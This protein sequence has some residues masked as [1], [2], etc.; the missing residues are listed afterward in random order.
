M[1]LAALALAAGVPAAAQTAA[2]AGAPQSVLRT[3]EVAKPPALPETSTTAFVASPPKPPKGTDTLRTTV[4]FGYVQG[5]DW[6]TELLAGGAVWGAQVQFNALVTKGYDGL[7]F[8]QGSLSV[9][10]PDARWRIEAGDVFSQLRGANLGAR[11]SWAAAGA[12]R[13]SVAFYTPRRGL[14]TQRTAVSY[15]DQIVVRGQT[16]L[17]AEVASDRSYFVRSRI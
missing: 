8:D 14:V 2:G 13:P 16:L 15:R 7:V 17:D 5:A 3:F 6:G 9:F 10:D 1:A 11:L 4:G 12:R